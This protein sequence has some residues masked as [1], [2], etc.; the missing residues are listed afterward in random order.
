MANTV[1]STMSVLFVSAL[2]SNR[3][4]SFTSE[5]AHTALS[6]DWTPHSQSGFLDKESHVTVL[7]LGE[8]G[9]SVTRFPSRDTSLICRNEADA[10]LKK[11]MRHSFVS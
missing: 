2:D 1:T 11:V 6:S 5:P 7:L 9:K 3:Y 8:N 10:F 4:S